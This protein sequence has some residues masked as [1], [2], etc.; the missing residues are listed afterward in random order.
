MEQATACSSFM[1]PFIP[2]AK[3]RGILETPNKSQITSTKLQTMPKFKCSK[4][5]T[6]LNL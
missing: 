2:D 6:V 3:H 5:Q 4:S 1:F